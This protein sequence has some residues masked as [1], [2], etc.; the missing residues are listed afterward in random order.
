MR[1]NTNNF[2]ELVNKIF[3]SKNGKWLTKKRLS[4]VSLISIGTIGTI[5]PVSIVL[6]N[7]NIVEPQPIGY[8]FAG[9]EFLTK[10]EVYNYAYNEAQRTFNYETNIFKFDN[11]LFNTKEDL[12]LYINQKFKITE[13]KTMR[14]PGN[15]TINASGELSS[16]IVTSNVE[17]EVKVYRGHDNQAYLSRDN[18]LETYFNYES[19]IFVEGKETNNESDARSYYEEIKLKELEKS[20]DKTTCYLQS[21]ICQTETEIKSWLRKNMTTGFEYNGK[22]FSDYNYLEYE[23]LIKPLDPK[24]SREHIKEVLDADKK[25][26]WAQVGNLNLQNGYLVGPKYF[27]S[28]EEIKDN[29]IKFEQTGS[30]DINP[31]IAYSYAVSLSSM[32]STVIDIV[33]PWIHKPNKDEESNFYSLKYLDYLNESI[34]WSKEGK[35]NLNSVLKNIDES[36]FEDA[37]L[38]LNLIK[39]K[40]FTNFN[41]LLV[42]FNKLLIK[43]RVHRIGVSYEELEKSFVYI[44]ADIINSQEEMVENV[45]SN[46]SENGLE[47]LRESSFED[48]YSLFIN[49]DKFYSEGGANKRLL[50]GVV[51]FQKI[52]ETVME[53]LEKLNKNKKKTE[54]TFK[55]KD[56]SQLKIDSNMEEIHK[57][58]QKEIESKSEDIYKGIGFKGFTDKNYNSKASATSLVSGLSWVGKAWS[59]SQALSFMSVVSFEAKLDQNTSLFY[60][61]PTIKIP[62]INIS[63]K[64]PNP[65]VN[66]IK[67][68]DSA[69]NYLVPKNPESSTTT[70]YEFKNKYYLHKDTAEEELILDAYKNPQNYFSSRKI[71]A[72]IMNKNKVYTLTNDKF[73]KPVN[74]SGGFTW[75]EY[76]EALDKEKEIFIEQLFKEEYVMHKKEYYLDGF[77]NAFENKYDAISSLKENIA[78]SKFNKKYFYI[79][80]NGEKIYKD[81]E[82]E[83]ISFIRINQPIESKLIINSDLIKTSIYD[84]L[85][86]YQGSQYDFYKLDFYGQNKYFKTLNQLLT[87]LDN[88][89]NYQVINQNG[90]LKTFDFKDNI[91]LN[92][93]E[94]RKWIEQQTHEVY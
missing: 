60:T 5:V 28:T 58:N 80:K 46:D 19:S 56:T 50:D 12:D 39:D 92:E 75:S 4:I 76:Q 10:E 21:G 9:K 47:S 18:A 34:S 65:K 53:P 62:L 52:A 83:I 70:I 89:I 88:N 20:D 66:V 82:E 63:I 16:D 24:L 23:N 64:K 48:I 49:V 81:S 79:M 87:Y 84:S 22:S 67:I 40:E 35:E 13:E 45:F 30:V 77:G 29:N 33:L 44:L 17:E 31:L 69:I 91:F 73:N 27:E 68:S 6:T 93:W 36:Y 85:E 26:Y 90:E 41:K 32:T 25:S 94:F 7:N 59:I 11:Q 42:V 15:Y 14:N 51:K 61:V 86:E 3:K 78:N 72:S 2:T 38:D 43:S 37:S 71:F 8:S 74:S 55:D 1:K 54:N 57:E